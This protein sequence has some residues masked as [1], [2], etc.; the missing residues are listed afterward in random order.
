MEACW[1][2]RHPGTCELIPF[3]KTLLLTSSASGFLRW[4]SFKNAKRKKDKRQ[5]QGEE[6][7]FP[8]MHSLK[9][10]Q[11]FKKILMDICNPLCLF[12]LIFQ[13]W[14]LVPCYSSSSQGRCSWL[15]W[16]LY[17][18]LGG[19]FKYVVFTPYLGKWSNFTQ[20]FP[21]GWNHQLEV[22]QPTTDEILSMCDLMSKYLVVKIVRR[23]FHFTNTS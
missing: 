14:V 16:Q 21:M 20:F 3:L 1:S 11:V 19:A 4:Q 15:K 10:A 18:S 17:P 8:Q 7:R 22:F 9:S 2:V 13:G 6:W 12:V 23:T 5:F